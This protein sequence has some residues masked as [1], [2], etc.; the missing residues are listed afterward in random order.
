[1]GYAKEKE[2]Y[3]KEQYLELERNATFKS[4]Y[5]HGEII[6]M[7]GTS[8]KHN[9]ICG[10]IFA[11]L[12]IHLRN[13]PCHVYIADIRVYV[14]TTG[15]FTY[16]NVLITCG[17][18]K[19]YDNYKD[20]LLNPICIIEVLSESTERYDRGEKFLHYQKIDSLK[21]YILVS[22]DRVLV[23]SFQ[24]QDNGKWLYHKIDNPSEELDIGSVQVKIKLE[25]IY[26]GVE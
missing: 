17:E 18:E 10:N 16:P 4:E 19:L 22:Q 24:K 1:M 6:A 26:T 12:H 2:I 7:A 3:T 25:E 20:T 21:E 5:I 15:L 14:Q 23:E 9:S 11:F 8:R 13:K